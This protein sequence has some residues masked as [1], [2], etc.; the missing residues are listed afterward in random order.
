M[1]TQGI[2][3]ARGRPDPA[4]V[5]GNGFTFV[6]RYVSTTGNAKN[7]TVAEARSYLAAGLGV[8]VVFE[9]DAERPFGGASVGRIDGMSAL[10]QVTALG[11][12]T[13]CPV[14]AAVDSDVTAGQMRD[15]LAY[16]RAF[17][18]AVAPHPLGVY[19]GYAVI[20]AVVDAGV[21]R[22]LWQ[23]GAWS[24]GKRHPAAQLRQRIGTVTVDGVAVDVD[25]ALVSDFGAWRTGIPEEDGMTP[26]DKAYIDGKFTAL[27]EA[28]VGKKRTDTTDSEPAR[29]TIRDLIAIGHRNEAAT[30]EVAVQLGALADALGRLA[31]TSG[32]DVPTLAAALLDGLGARLAPSG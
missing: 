18:A 4:K 13:R 16:L 22:Y 12:P 20:D 29:D 2:D 8:V 7:L 19:G 14:Y 5:R 28:L 23:A 24:Q 1:S 31:A 27:Y 21:A 17:G 30:R 3:F 11:L 6:V 15:V 32:I 9:R 10:A 25:D 26:E